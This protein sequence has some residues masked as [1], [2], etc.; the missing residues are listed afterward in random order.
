MLKRADVSLDGFMWGDNILG[1][2]GEI[3][4]AIKA[5]RS[6]LIEIPMK[7]TVRLCLIYL[8]III[9]VDLCITII[10]GNSSANK[11]NSNKSLV[12]NLIIGHVPDRGGRVNEELRQVN[13]NNDSNNRSHNSYSSKSYSKKKW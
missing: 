1:R 12:K 4:A 9:N 6:E 5:Q 13:S 8:V 3:V 10:K 11:R 2:E 7:Y